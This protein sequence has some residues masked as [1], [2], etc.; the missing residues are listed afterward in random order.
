MNAMDD[1][2]FTHRLLRKGNSGAEHLEDALSAVARTLAV[3]YP[4]SQIKTFHRHR[5]GEI[6]ASL[7][8]NTSPASK[9]VEERTSLETHVGFQSGVEFCV[10][11]SGNIT[12]DGIYIS[13][14]DTKPP[15]TP[16]NINFNLP[17]GHLVSADGTSQWFCT[18][19]SETNTDS[20]GMG[21]H[22]QHLSPKDRVE[23]ARF[24]SP[25]QASQQESETA[26][27]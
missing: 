8:S 9:R 7:G 11:V 3:L 24:V 6:Q 21:V 25:Q 14:H 5:A 20:S 1:L 22:F 19:D 12:T 26:S 10:G 15:G 4:I 23:I 2:R 13:T 17:N 18:V 16:V 27:S